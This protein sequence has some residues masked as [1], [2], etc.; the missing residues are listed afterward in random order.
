MKVQIISRSSDNSRA[1]IVVITK[2][3]NGKKRSETLHV[4]RVNG[5]IYKDRTG[6]T[7]EL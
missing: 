2:G 5:K 3:A 1:Q 4:V 6:A 7:Y